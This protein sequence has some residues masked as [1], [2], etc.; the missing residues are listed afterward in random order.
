MVPLLQADIEYWAHC[1]NGYGTLLVAAITGTTQVNFTIGRPIG[2]V[3]GIY[4]P[5]HSIPIVLQHLPTFL[6]GDYNLKIKKL[7]FAVCLK[8]TTCL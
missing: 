6:H 4:K 3:P 8:T 5:L 2:P 7:M 1:A